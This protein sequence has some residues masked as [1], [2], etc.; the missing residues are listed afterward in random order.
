MARPGWHQGPA[1]APAA[2]VCSKEPYEEPEMPR[3][4]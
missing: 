1:D 2:L 4:M 3:K